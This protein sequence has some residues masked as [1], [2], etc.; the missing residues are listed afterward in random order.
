MNTKT[1]A[2]KLD[3]A[4]VIVSGLPQSPVPKP[5]TVQVSGISIPVLQQ[6][7]HLCR[8]GYVPDVNVPIFF[9]PESGSMSISLV[10]GSPEQAY[11]DLAHEKLGDAQAAQA[12]AYHRDV[13]AAAARLIADAEQ[14]K[15]DAQRA[16]LLAA[17]AAAVA[18]LDA[19]LAAV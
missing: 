13:E 19:D 4:T 16:E 9:N 18:K 11:V 2:A 5:H 7:A 15:R 6:L 3:T 17:H 10:I 1:N 12:A 8:A 14:A